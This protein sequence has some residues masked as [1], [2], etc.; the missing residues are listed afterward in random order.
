MTIAMTERTGVT[1]GLL[2]WWWVLVSGGGGGQRY[3]IAFN[4]KMLYLYVLH[5]TE[6]NFLVQKLKSA[7]NNTCFKRKTNVK[8]SK[9]H[10]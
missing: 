4:L 10:S 1:S 3:C 5:K 8:V 6:G 9:F 2:K 7:G